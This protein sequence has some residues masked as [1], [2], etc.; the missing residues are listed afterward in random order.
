PAR[1]PSPAALVVAQLGEE[2]SR[3]TYSNRPG[4]EGIA[5]LREGLDGEDPARAEVDQSGAAR[6]LRLS[7]GNGVDGDLRGGVHRGRPGT[8]QGTRGTGS[9]LLDRSLARYR[10]PANEDRPARRPGAKRN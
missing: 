7:E 9:S 4:I 1:P 5:D 8:E 10:R 2:T 3:A 6:G